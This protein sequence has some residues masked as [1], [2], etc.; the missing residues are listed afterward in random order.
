MYHHTVGSVRYRF[1]DLRALLAKASPA[2]SGDSLAGLAA[3]SAEE[4]VAAQMALADLPL[5]ALLDQPV[6]PYETDDV[7]RLIAD[8]CLSEDYTDFLT[9]PAYELV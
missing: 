1:D 7:S 8:I 4:R 6:I 5:R 2:R 3:A 9:T